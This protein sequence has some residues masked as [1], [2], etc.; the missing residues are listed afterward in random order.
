MHACTRTNTDATETPCSK[1]PF[2]SGSALSS[3]SG[4]G[5]VLLLFSDFPSISQLL[6]FSAHVSVKPAEYPDCPL[7]SRHL[8]TVFVFGFVE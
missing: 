5:S 4:V 8:D 1:R 7:N 2:V 3:D 6:L